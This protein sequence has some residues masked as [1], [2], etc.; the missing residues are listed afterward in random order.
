MVM[1]CHGAGIFVSNGGFL[2]LTNDIPGQIWTL[3]KAKD[4]GPIPP[5]SADTHLHTAGIE[6]VIVPTSVYRLQN[7]GIQCAD[8]YRILACASL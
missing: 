5:S 8:A 6:E 7:V 4:A 1:D 2:A 3:A